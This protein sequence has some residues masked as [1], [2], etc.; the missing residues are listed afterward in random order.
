MLFSSILLR[1]SPQS[2]Q[3]CR[4]RRA[5]A[6]L[7][8]T[9][10]F[11]TS[12]FTAIATFRGK[13]TSCTCLSSSQRQTLQS[14]RRTSELTQLLVIWIY[15]PISAQSPKYK[16]F[17]QN[18]NFNLRSDPQKHFLWASRLW[19]GRLKEPKLSHKKKKKKNPGTNG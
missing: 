10:C 15:Q 2:L 3:A 16:T 4:W 14:L 19:L 6:W 1:L 8:P 18:F 13:P 5:V 11:I 17:G 12:N 9:E 7:R